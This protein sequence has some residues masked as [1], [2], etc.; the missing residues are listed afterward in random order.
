MLSI[1][2]DL[3]GPDKIKYCGTEFVSCKIVLMRY[4]LLWDCWRAETFTN[5]IDLTS[6]V[7]G[8]WV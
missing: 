8:K 3:M 1:S 2:M 5:V 4:R 6:P 7:Q